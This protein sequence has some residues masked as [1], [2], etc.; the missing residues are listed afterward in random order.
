MKGI[1]L[2]GGLGTRLHPLTRITNKHLLPV[3]DKPMVFY[4]IQ[5]LVNA[6]IKDI[7][8]VTGGNNAGDFL[9]LLANG[10]DFGLRHLNYGYQEGE[11]GI[12]AALKV[13][14]PFVEGHRICVVLGDNI[15]EKSIK[16]A[17]DA[18]KA[19]PSGGK[20][21]LKEVPDPQ[22]FGV[23]VFDENNRVIRVEEKPADPKSPYAVTG[24][25][26]YDA[27]VFEIINTLKPSGRGELEITDVNN[28]Y[29]ERGDLTYDVLDGWW[30]DA[31]TFDSLLKVSNLVARTGANNL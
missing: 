15:I 23:P 14:E 3:Y 2:A 6:G 9:R 7:M 13:A 4:P 24:I 19:Q 26:M 28:A 27:D 31:G 12:A 5:A 25:Y 17:V 10:A 16:G 30:A 1:V 22:R 29:L 18:Y 8:V 11:G 21:L 20:I